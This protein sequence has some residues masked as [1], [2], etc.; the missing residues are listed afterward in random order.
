M[1]TS[2]ASSEISGETKTYV[3][4]IYEG[5]G[6]TIVAAVVDI[7]F[8]EVLGEQVSPLACVPLIRIVERDQVLCEP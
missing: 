5:V 6:V 8:Q 7:A 3:I 4:V 2:I 1:R